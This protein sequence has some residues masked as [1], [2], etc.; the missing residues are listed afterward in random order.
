MDMQ[1]NKDLR[2]N[3]ENF[4]QEDALELFFNNFIKQG[5]VIK[6]ETVVP[7]MKV[8]LKVLDTGELLAAESILALT[9]PGI[10][11]DVIQKVRAASILSQSV[12]AIN[13]MDVEDEKL[14]SE[15]N[16]ARRNNLYKNLLKMPAFVVTKIY[17]LYTDAVA[18]QNELYT[19]GGL[20]GKIENF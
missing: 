18:E 14:T 16:K 15:V 13:G 4:K 11:V 19:N 2:E 3:V 6:E 20:V 9:N 8:K 10:P 12:M 5:N 7:G 1:E 17:K